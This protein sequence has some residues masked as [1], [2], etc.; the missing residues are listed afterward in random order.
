MCY[1]F[2][3]QIKPVI[4]YNSKIWNFAII[5]NNDSLEGIHYK[6]C[7]FTLRVSTNATNLAVYGELGC[8]PL[9]VCR[10]V[11]VVKYWQ[12]LWNENMDLPIYLREAYLLAKCES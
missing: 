6:F 9:S 3:M 8:A 4:D 7:K 2:D 11:Q 12:R 10:K 5:D 1:L